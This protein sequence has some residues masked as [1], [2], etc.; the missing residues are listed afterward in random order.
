[1]HTA[2]RLQQVLRSGWL[3]LLGLPCAAMLLASCWSQ[4]V[5]VTHP[6]GPEDLPVVLAHGLSGFRTALGADYFFRVPAALRADGHQVFVTNVPPWGPVPLR[7]QHLAEQVD[8]ILR[9]THARAVH[10]VAHSM[11]G[12]DARYMI[13]R[14]QKARAV[15]SLTTV[16]TPHR[17]SAVADR[18]S[19]VNFRPTHPLQDFSADF[20]FGTL[21]GINVPSDTA[22]AVE[23]L[24]ETF[25]EGFNRQV[26]DASGVRYY[27]FAGR[28]LGHHGH[29][30][31][32]DAL[33]RP[34]PGRDAVVPM[35]AATAVFL[36]GL[37]PLH[38]RANDGLVTVASARWGIFVACVPADHMK[39][40]GQPM[41][42]APLP[43]WDHVAFYRSW[44]EEL[45]SGRALAL[46]PSS[47]PK[48][49]AKP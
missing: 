42:L 20:F 16:G 13:S 18:Y 4:T 26:P 1:M 48:P 14:L 28:T 35:L 3:T 12:L 25:A 43:T 39:L 45:V 24:S 49:A 37:D 36:S 27:S 32:D 17:G 8:Q 34:Y 9:T 21:G 44:V 40:V 47:L 2:K 15:A 6:R 30:D 38:P 11:G 33:R 5:Q 29:P 31:C 22:G 19:D 7:A 10:I 41:M 23:T 46:K